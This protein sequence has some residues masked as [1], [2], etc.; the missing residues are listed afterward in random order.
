MPR[1]ECSGMAWEK[2]PS[3]EHEC[4][5]KEHDHPIVGLAPQQQAADREPHTGRCNEK[6]A[7]HQV[8]PADQEVCDEDCERKDKYADPSGPSEEEPASILTEISH[9]VL[10]LWVWKWSG[11]RCQ[12]DIHATLV[13]VAKLARLSSSISTCI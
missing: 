12:S 13:V 11:C 6:Q 7:A 8:E 1:E 10:A 2:D 9:V 4:Q 3:Y 5:G